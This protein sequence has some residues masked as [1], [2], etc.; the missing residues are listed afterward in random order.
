MI[1]FSSTFLRKTWVCWTFNNIKI[2]QNNIKHIFFTLN[3]LVLQFS[4]S[5]CIVQFQH[6]TPMCDAT[7]HIF[8]WFQFVKK[9]LTNV[10]RISSMIF[11]E[12]SSTSCW[13]RYKD[14][15]H[16][17]SLFL[18]H[19]NYGKLFWDYRSTHEYQTVKEMYVVHIFIYL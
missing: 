8:F 4:N 5:T 18:F 13:N 11:L 2:S 19:K 10:S 16:L 15:I 1:P 17:L 7:S 14:T 6:Y 12:N 9:M 3:T